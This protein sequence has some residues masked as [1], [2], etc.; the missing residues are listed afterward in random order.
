M[1][2]AL[3]EN[4][5]YLVVDN[6]LPVEI[7]EELYTMYVNTEE[8]KWEQI[9]QERSKHYEHVFKMP[10][11][12]LP[13]EDEVYIAKFGRN[14]SIESSERFNQ[15]YKE[16]IFPALIEA[17]QIQMTESDNRC[18][19]LLPK[20]LYRA[21]ID[22]Y[23][24]KI[25]LVYYINKKWKWDWGGILHV[26]TENGKDLKSILPVFN[27]AVILAH[28]LFRFPHFVSSVEDFA[29]EPRYSIVSFTK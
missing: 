1:K 28:E 17:T 25:G 18:Y 23:I 2:H 21:H 14:K 9:S 11:A 29:K 8:S 19:R 22:D 26:V 4:Q 27:R 15:I 13:D 7:A 3:M 12:T 16:Y 20:D 10:E 5:G 6:F 24:A